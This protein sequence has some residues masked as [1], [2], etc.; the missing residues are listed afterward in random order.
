MPLLQCTTR[1]GAARCCVPVE[2]ATQMNLLIGPRDHWFR[3]DL[4][5]LQTLIR[6]EH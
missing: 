4:P 3:G 1:D 5:D 2:M 6:S